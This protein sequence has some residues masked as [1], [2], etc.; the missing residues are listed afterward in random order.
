MSAEKLTPGIRKAILG[1]I[2]RG[3]QLY[4]ASAAAGVAPKTVRAWE[5]TA[6]TE[7]DAES[8]VFLREIQAALEAKTD[9]L[10]AIRDARLE[11]IRRELQAGKTPGALGNVQLQTV[12]FEIDLRGDRLRAEV[13]KVDPKAA[14]ELVRKAFSQTFKDEPGGDDSSDAARSAAGGR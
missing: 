6:Q 1:Y 11:A 2:G 3:C 13:P 4:Q 14:A 7:P 9:S 10:V 8:A 12:Q 5:A